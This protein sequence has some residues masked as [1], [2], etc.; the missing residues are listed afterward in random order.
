MPSDPAYETIAAASIDEARALQER[1]STAVREEPGPEHIEVVA[2]VDVAYPSGEREARAAV[3]LWHLASG[4][5]VARAIASV[6]LTFP[7]LPGYLA[8]R[9]LP[10]VLA[11]WRG[12]SG[13]PDVVLCDG[14]GR[15]HPR[16]C[17]LA[18]LV[19]LALGLPTIGCAKNALTGRHEALGWA[20]G[21]RTPLFDGAEIV[22]AALRTRSGVRPVFVSIGHRI[23][24]DKACEVVLEISRFRLPEPLRAAHAA[25]QAKTPRP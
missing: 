17:G 1:L 14:H 6:R 22:G 25:A 19:G 8:W 5:V 4:R 11:A 15:A 18:C 3:V 9:E 13:R 12:V 20:R 7:Y 21:S 2:G 10:A 16:R 23:T 24:L